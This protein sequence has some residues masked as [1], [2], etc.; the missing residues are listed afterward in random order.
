MKRKELEKKY[1]KKLIKKIFNEDYLNGC[2]I[3]IIDGE[4]DIPEEDIVNVIKEIKGEPT[5][6]WD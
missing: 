1:G 6:D 5:E 2:T 3:A 4:E